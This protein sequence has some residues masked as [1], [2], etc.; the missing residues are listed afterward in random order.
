M[1]LSYS[2]VVPEGV[3]INVM[4]SQSMVLSGEG[5]NVSEMTPRKLES[6]FL[7]FSDAPEDPSVC[8]K[9]KKGHK[10]KKKTIRDG[11]VLRSLA[12]YRCGKK[13]IKGT[14]KNTTFG[15]GL[16]MQ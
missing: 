14:E 4:T 3:A 10:E 12:Y 2:S 9:R 16:K 13:K 8:I 11:G 6:P 7:T 1:A 5:A 15:G